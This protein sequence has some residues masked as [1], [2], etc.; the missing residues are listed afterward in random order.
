MSFVVNDPNLVFDEATHTYTLGDRVLPSVTSILA[1]AGLCDFSAPWFTDAVKLRG[2]LVHETLAIFDEGDLDEDTLDPTLEPYLAGYRRFLDDT[3]AVV[4]HSE[5]R[6]CHPELGFAGTLDKI[7][8]IEEPN[9]RVRRLLIDVKPAVYPSVGPQTAAYA[10]CADALYDAVT[11]FQRAALVLAG[12]G[13][14]TLHMLTDQL[15][16]HYFL[17]A[18]RVSQFRQLHGLSKAIAA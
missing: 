16:R 4:E 8:R 18:L 5:R 12:D 17:A 14:Y 7:V 3:N 2:Q 1:D 13:K 6:L 11:I 10:L 15:D 9:G